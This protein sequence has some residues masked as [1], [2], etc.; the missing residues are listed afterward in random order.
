V[1]DRVI[2]R[3]DDILYFGRADGTL[4]HVFPD[5]ISRWIIASTE[6]IDEYVVEQPDPAHLVVDLEL[7][8]VVAP[9]QVARQV[10]DAIRRG[11]SQHGLASPE[12]TVRSAPGVNRPGPGKFKRFR[13]GFVP[14]AS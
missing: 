3:D 12:I 11:L 13:R 8:G 10:T 5:V 7:S 1:I 2:G 4:G 9:E 14:L 6:G